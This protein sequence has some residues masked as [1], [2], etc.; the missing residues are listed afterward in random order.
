MSFPL[1]VLPPSPSFAWRNNPT[2]NRVAAGCALSDRSSSY[3]YKPLFFPGGLYR[4]ND[5]WKLSTR[6]RFV[7]SRIRTLLD[8]SEDWNHEAWGRP[9]S[10][11][12]LGF[13]I[14]VFS[15]RL[16]EYS[17][18]VG[19]DLDEE[20]RE[21]VLS[22]WRYAGY[23]MGIPETVLYTTAAEAEEMYKIGY[24]CEPAPDA[25]SIAVANGLIQ[26][27]P[28]VADV[29]DP[30]ERQKLTELAYRLSRALIGNKLAE[31]FDF[32]KTPVVGTL[33]LYRMKQRFQRMLKGGSLVRSGNFTQLLQLSVYDDYGV[34][35]EMPDH[36]KHSKSNP[37]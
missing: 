34:T 15:Q 27:I 24:M 16:L 21:S 36:A 37:W 7:H 25:D 33:F 13:A 20:E 6:I 11:A 10:A 2:S 4:E 3:G 5:G 9:V 30:V 26:A 18:Q 28:S 19:A 14:S 17:R 12:H 31:R 23:L 8:K 22:V 1:H 29:T 35:Y 32:P